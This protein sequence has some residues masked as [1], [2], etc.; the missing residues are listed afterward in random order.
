V[1]V[2]EFWEL[3]PRET[4]AVIDAALWREER[5]QRRDVALAWHVAALSRTKRLPSLKQLLNTKPAKPLKGKELERRRKE[6][7]EATANLDLSKLT[8]RK[9]KP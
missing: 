8:K 1:T 5:Q 3:T 2:S 6:F 7:R 4:F 9:R